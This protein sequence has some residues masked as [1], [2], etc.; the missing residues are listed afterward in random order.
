MGK[1][2]HQTNAFFY[3]E[4]IDLTL[5][6]SCRTMKQRFTKVSSQYGGFGGTQARISAQRKLSSARR[7]ALTRASRIPASL[8]AQP[9]TGPTELKSTDQAT[10][11]IAFLTAGTVALVVAPPLEGA[12]FYQRVGRRIRM[13]SIELRGEIQ[14]SN[15]NAAAVTRQFARL[16]VIYDRQ[17]N[18]ALPAVADILTGYNAAGATSSTVYDGLNMNNRDRFLVLRDRKLYLPPLGINGATPAA[19]QGVALV[20]NRD[21]EDLLIREFIKLKGTVWFPIT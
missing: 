1:I 8:M 17:A 19:S 16:L 7:A 15:G 5:T 2:A 12:S 18:G 10:T 20:G 11:A 4:I 14:P 3:P 21:N 13:K 6:L 9:R